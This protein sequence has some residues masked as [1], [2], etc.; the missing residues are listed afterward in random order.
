MEQCEK[1]P[2]CADRADGHYKGRIDDL[3]TLWNAEDQETEELG[4]FNEYGL[5]FDYVLDGT[6]ED[7]DD[8]GY[9]RYQLSTGGPGDEF[10][11]YVDAAGHCYR[12]EYWFLDWYD[13]ASI[14]LTD[15][16][17][18]LLLEIFENFKDMGLV[19]SEL[20]KARG[21]ER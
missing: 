10:R 4:T 15:D 11:F 20:E 19:D 3:R 13:G 2:T 17:K 8:G 6:F 12:V 9:F 1:Y 5:C 7:Q 16:D 21:E 14:T 18:A